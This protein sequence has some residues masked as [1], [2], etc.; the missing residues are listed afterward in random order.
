MLTFEALSETSEFAKKWVPFCK[1]FNVEPRAPEFYFAHKL[2]YLKDKIVPLFVKERRAIKTVNTHSRRANIVVKFI[3]H[4]GF[5]VE[6][7]VVDFSFV[8][9]DARV[10]NIFALSLKRPN[11]WIM[12]VVPPARREIE[13]FNFFSVTTDASTTSTMPGTSAVVAASKA[14]DDNGAAA[15]TKTAQGMILINK[16]QVFHR[17]HVLEILV[18]HII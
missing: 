13:L 10:R 2:D 15:A 5:T 11:C 6:G 3:D 4:Y 1:K 18:K 17:F 7:N 9:I 16:F 14:A 8:I 12:M